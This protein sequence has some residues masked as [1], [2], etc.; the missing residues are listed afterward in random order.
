VLPFECFPF[1]KIQSLSWDPPLIDALDKWLVEL[2]IVWVFRSIYE[3][4]WMRYE[5]RRVAEV[6]F[7]QGR[8]LLDYAKGQSRLLAMHRAGLVCQ[9]PCRCLRF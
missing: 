1:V 2:G 5:F 7:A 4:L 3:N 6:Q 8:T 9:K